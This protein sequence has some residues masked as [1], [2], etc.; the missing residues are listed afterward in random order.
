MT[1]LTLCQNCGK[2]PATENWVGE[3]GTLAYVHGHYQRWC[4]RCCIE[5]Q[6]DNARKAAERIPELEKRLEELKCKELETK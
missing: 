4:E 3:G 6:L 1:E 2:R 5:A